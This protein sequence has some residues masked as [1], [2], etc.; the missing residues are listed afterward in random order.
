MKITHLNTYTEGGAAEAALRLHTA[1]LSIGENSKFIALYKGRCAQKE[2]YDFRDELSKINYWFTKVKNKPRSISISHI[3][4]AAGEWYNELNT[5]WNAGSHSAVKN[6]DIIHLHWV[7]GFVDLPSFLKQDK[8][9]IFTLHDHFLFSGGFHYPPPIKGIVSENKI[10][11]QKQLI[12]KIVSE[13]PIEIVCPSQ[14]LK[15][16]AQNSGI[17]SKCNFHVIKNPVDTDVFTTEEKARCRLKLNIPNDKK[18][19][20]F[21]SDYINYERKGFQVLEKT[22]ALLD[23]EITL[24][25]AG[26]GELPDKIGKATLK[27]FGLV[28]DK[29]LL[30]QLYGA[31]DFLVNPS[32]NDISSNTV[33]EAMACGRPAIVFNSGG[34]PELVSEI[35]GLISP[36]KTSQSLALTINQ[37][38]KNNYNPKSIRDK[39]LKEHAL[40]VIAE[41]YMKIYH[42]MK[43]K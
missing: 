14:H 41:Q 1:L 18:V 16:L 29:T 3:S 2:V 31:C 15:E 30:N 9:I 33:I 17:L 8:K 4:K 24:I 11:T 22:L 26:R 25:V 19:L 32:L 28:K 36:D 6:A 35:N 34:V 43:N 13:H 5:V 7:S 42:E 40:K 10:D 20:F 27:H 37:A 39:A 21:I 23:E 38:L 12:K